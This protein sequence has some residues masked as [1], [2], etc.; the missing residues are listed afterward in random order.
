[1]NEDKHPPTPKIKLSNKGIG[2]VS[3]KQEAHQELPKLMTYL[4]CRDV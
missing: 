4:Y 2:V 3:R 1:M